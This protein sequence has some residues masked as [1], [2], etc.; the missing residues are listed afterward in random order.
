MIKTLCV[1][2]TT[3]IFMGCSMMPY[4]N[5]FQ[6]E[7][8]KNSGVCASLSEVYAMSDNTEDIKKQKLTDTDSK[9]EKCEGCENSKAKTESIGSPIANSSLVVENE[10][11]KQM[12]EALE[13]EKIQREKRVTAGSASVYADQTVTGVSIKE[14]PLK[15]TSHSITASSDNAQDMDESIADDCF[16]SNHDNKKYSIKK[17]AEI[18]VWRANIRKEPSCKAEVVK[19]AKKGDGLFADYEQNGW[20][21]VNDGYVH[22]SIITIKK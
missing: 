20:V 18:C 7:K 1:I 4:N 12:V 17:M 19:I 22:K 11:L 10:Y 6:C 14:E 21:K 8:G 2:L 16:Q 5:T 3:S 9:D 13:I 15:I